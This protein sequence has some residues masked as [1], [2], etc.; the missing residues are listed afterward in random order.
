[1]GYR[2]PTVMEVVYLAI[3]LLVAAVILPKAGFAGKL[4]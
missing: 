2:G 4:H 3:A 1:M